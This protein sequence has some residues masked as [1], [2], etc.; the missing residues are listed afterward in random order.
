M[1]FG[2]E[3]EQA[4]VPEWREFYVGYGRLKRIIKKQAIRTSKSTMS[5][6]VENNE[7][8]PLLTVG[9][10]PN[11]DT[12]TNRPETFQEAIQKELEEVDTFF[13]A[14]LAQCRKD[15]I[16]IRTE[17][18][19]GIAAMEQASPVPGKKQRRRFKDESPDK[20]LLK[21]YDM[22]E[23]VQQFSKLNHTGF[24]KIVKKYDKITG[25]ETLG[26]FLIKMKKETKFAGR[27]DEE[28]AHM[29][30]DINLLYMQVSND[31]THTAKDILAEQKA[32]Q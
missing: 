12:T 20:R 9:S 21:L 24:R 8:R 25:Q 15:Y 23:N 19:Q 16:A 13:L 2:K 3:I 7:T 10:V 6:S 30:K 32:A 11:F 17:V 27:S 22:V 14:Q 26:D 28:M 4:A 29:L 18:R 1:K 5:L 31:P